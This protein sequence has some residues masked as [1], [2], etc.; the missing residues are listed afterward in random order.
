MDQNHVSY[1]WTTAQYRIPIL[2][3]SLWEFNALHAARLG[4]QGLAAER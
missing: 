2:A 4:F 3:K 1:H